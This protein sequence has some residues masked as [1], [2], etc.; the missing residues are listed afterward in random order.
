M[1]KKIIKVLAIM[2]IGGTVVGMTGCKSLI[3]GHEYVTYYGCPNSKKIKKLN[4]KK[5]RG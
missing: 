5:K 4:T 3:P 1:K 2:L